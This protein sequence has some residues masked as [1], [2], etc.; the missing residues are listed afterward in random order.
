M[1]SKAGKKYRRKVMTISRDDEKQEQA[2]RRQ[3]AEAFEKAARK[4]GN[5]KDEHA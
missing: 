2:H 4:D 3:L 5:R 1:G